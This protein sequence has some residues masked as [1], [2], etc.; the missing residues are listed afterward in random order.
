MCA[1]DIPDDHDDDLVDN[2]DLANLD[3]NV[4]HFYDDNNNDDDA[5]VSIAFQP[6]SARHD[7]RTIR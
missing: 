1:Y 2:N 6:E 3:D 7:G 4:E 5:G